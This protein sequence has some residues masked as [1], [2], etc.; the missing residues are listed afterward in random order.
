MQL[1]RTKSFNIYILRTDCSCWCHLRQAEDYLL[2]SLSSSDSHHY[3]T[4]GEPNPSHKL[5]HWQNE[6]PPT[7]VLGRAPN[8]SHNLGLQRRESQTL[9]MT[10]ESKPYSHYYLLTNPTL[11][12]APIT[13]HPK[14]VAFPR[15]PRLSHLHS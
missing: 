14:L 3:S 15:S 8:P 9:P 13:E 10:G 7:S 1:S 4:S 12:L 5:H 11:N 2:R 6:T